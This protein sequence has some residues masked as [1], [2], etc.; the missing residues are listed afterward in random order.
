[1][2]VAEPG[3]TCMGIVTA[4]LM[5]GT[6]RRAQKWLRKCGQRRTTNGG[7]CMLD[8]LLHIVVLY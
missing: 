4:R 8:E 6:K 1:M 5:E 2:L 7:L 3:M